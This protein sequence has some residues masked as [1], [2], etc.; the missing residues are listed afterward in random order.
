MTRPTLR[1]TVYW[2]T[3]ILGPASFLIGGWLGVTRDPQVLAT[4][5]HLGY[6]E[7]FAAISGAWKILGALA[8]V[9]PGLPRLKEWA[10]AGFFFELTA[11]AV[12]RTAVGDG[13]SDILAPLAFLAL[14]V[15]SWALRPA[16]RRLVASAGHEAAEPSQAMPGR[17]VLS[18]R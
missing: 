4:L 1:T 17:P 10:Y 11:A 13:L 3:T 5:H 16:S 6:P 15:A 14:V 8:V 7:Y 9:A 12:S 2:V 18:T